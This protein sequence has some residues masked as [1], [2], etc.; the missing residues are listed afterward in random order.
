MTPERWRQVSEIFHA[1]IARDPRA[2]ESFLDEACRHDSTLR[3]EVDALVAAHGDA[4][5]FGE[6]PVAMTPL[7]AGSQLGSY[8]IDALIDA[9]GMGEVYR[10]R[11]TKLGR[12][13]AI[14][15]LPVHLTADPDRRA[16]FEREARILAALNHPHIAQI[17][18]FEEHD[19][20]TALVMEL[21]PGETLEAVLGHG[22][23]PLNLS[24]VV[25]IGR[26]IAEAL[27]AAHEKGIVHR[28][29]KPANIKR[30]PDLT[31]KVLDFGLAM[32][33]AASDG[34]TE[35]V[36]ASAGARTHTGA[37]LG[38]AAYMSPEQARGQPV[39]KRTDIWAFGCVLYELLTGRRAFDGDTMSDRI[40]A[41]LEREPDF[42]RL[43]ADTP[44]GMRRVL[45]RCLEK[46]PRRRLH[47]IVDA[48][49][50]LEDAVQP[51]ASIE[52]AVP[53]ARK[54]LGW[55]VTLAAGL[56]VGAVVITMLI[57]A[58]RNSSPVTPEVIRLSV[59]PPENWAMAP[60]F[61]ISPDGKQ[62]VF[63][64][65]SNGASRLW[66]QSFA[67][68]TARSLP[69]TEQG[70]SPFWSPDSRFV[71][72]FTSRELKKVSVS[73]GLPT[74]ICDALFGRGGTWNNDNQ[75]VFAPGTDS[76]LYRVSAEGGASMV[77]T[78][79]DETRLDTTHRF[80]QF[81]PDGRH[82]LY[83]AGGGATTPRLE[84]GSLDSSDVVHVLSA[85]RNNGLLKA[86]FG[87]GYLVFFRDGALMA[88]PFDPDALRTTGDP[89]RLIDGDL[90]QFSLS[91][92]GMLVY[93]PQNQQAQ[94]TWIDREGHQITTV[95][96][97]D[98]FQVALSPDERR[99]ATS[100][101]QSDVFIIDLSRGLPQQFTF[102]P[103]NDFFPVWSP[104]GS[105]LVFS[106]TRRGRYTLFERATNFV[107]EEKE[108]EFAS[109][110]TPRVIVAT[111]WS[112]DGRFIAASV[113]GDIWIIPMTGNRKAFPFRR[114]PANEGNAHFSK[115]GRWI[116][117]ASDE[118][119]RREVYVAPFPESGV[120]PKRL[121]ASGGTE[122]MWSRDGKELFFLGLDGS[123]MAVSDF[124][125][126]TPRKLFATSVASG[127]IGNQYAV[128]EHGTRFLVNVVHSKPLSLS[129]IIGWPG[130]VS[131]K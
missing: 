60:Q 7:V 48:R 114:T 39:D 100:N 36:T 57:V 70:G 91:T 80:P 59:V 10:A 120:G 21:V 40:A 125:N 51:P 38:T 45:R 85:G 72:F 17:Y 106:S 123:V 104:D 121:S 55:A 87:S 82:F 35:G 41:V 129:V 19:G 52:G 113:D 49:L 90:L 16:R 83:T 110:V 53:A 122:P 99:V 46:D 69:G 34:P 89:V 1:A 8:R 81:L 68:G 128:D 23:S 66:V 26:Q 11:D 92:T 47:D 93:A 63:A 78:R 44:D 127:G 28:D 37:I 56:I 29:L 71:A 5:A 15:L 43:P 54:G 13:V 76:E 30:T 116:A 9:G 109:D 65:A 50:D 33:E 86:I 107:G 42:S 126:Q 67:S 18:G 20:V 119:G 124:L 77:V 94:M 32:I 117:Y 79:K 97:P 130:L 62:V 31:V 115:D 25:S 6:S 2:R 95:G 58:R 74:K 102:N 111:D 14:K 131:G 96:D 4:G 22:P 105:Q 73:G 108:L 27:E 12:D 3:S 61:A 24:E 84:I 98:A 64:A 103:A 112:Q 101:G 75:I 118:T 88:Q